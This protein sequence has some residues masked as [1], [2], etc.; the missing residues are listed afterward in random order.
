M[1]A[2]GV[3]GGNGLSLFYKDGLEVCSWCHLACEQHS[4]VIFMCWMRSS[5]NARNWQ[6]MPMH[7]QVNH[8]VSLAP[9]SVSLLQISILEAKAWRC[10]WYW[11]EGLCYDDHFYIWLRNFIL[12]LTLKYQWTH[13][14]SPNSIG[15]LCT[16]HSASPT[17]LIKHSYSTDLL[18]LPGKWY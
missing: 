8:G 14:K 2:S 5:L 4:Y 18:P 7:P 11:G 9:S 15:F 3:I 1:V 16:L 17:D 10:G 12:F 6:S 13:E